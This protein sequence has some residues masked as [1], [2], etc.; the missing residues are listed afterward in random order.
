MADAP[1]V[2]QQLE[3]AYAQA[4]DALILKLRAGG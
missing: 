2:L 3:K 4:R 1:S